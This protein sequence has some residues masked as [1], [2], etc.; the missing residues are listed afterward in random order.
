MDAVLGTAGHIDHGKTSLI[1][2]LTGINCDRLAEEKRRGITIELGFAWLDLPD[3]RRLGIVDVPGHERFVKNMVAGAAGIDCVLLVIAADEGVMPQTREHLEI[4]QLLGIKAGIVALTKIDMVDRDWLEMVR[5]D[6]AA[7]LKGTFLEGAPMLEVSSATGEGIPGL[8]AAVYDLVSSLDQRKGSD[9]LRLP[10]DRVFTLKGHGTVVTGTLVSGECGQGEDVCVMPSGKKARAR[11]LQVH[12]NAVSHAHPGQRCAINLQGLEVSDIGRGDIVSQPDALFPSER[13]L[14]RLSCLAS[15]PLP[16]RQRMETHFHHGSAECAARV[17][18]LD[19]EELQPGESALAELRFEQPMVGIF[20]DR[21]VLRAHSPL[22]T[23]AG[24]VL[25]DPLPEILRRR[26]AV[27]AQKLASLGELANL[28]EMR[29]PEPVRLVGLA[30]AL[31]PLPG[32]N[33]AQLAVLTGLARPEIATALAQLLK[34]GHAV[35][36]NPETGAWVARSQFD[37]SIEC[38]RRRADELHRREPLKTRFAQGAF[39]A[40][41]GDG[42]PPK[43]IQK[44]IDEAARLGLLEQTA[45]GLRLA[46]RTAEL[47]ETQRRI[48]GRMEKAY[49]AENMSP[50]ALKEFCEAE[51]LEMKLVLAVAGHLCDTGKL[52]K[53]QEGFYYHADALAKIR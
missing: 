20:G 21:C 40:G 3:G 10:I 28:A 2:A 32:A 49:G 29:A 44:V 43:Y 19:C 35:C 34:E 48:L 13:W 30:L 24:A 42:L 25:L 41:W 51:R 18:L 53:I 37:A 46:G 27:F 39:C 47:S 23:I 36:W 1:A 45:S 6:V 26:D 22:R 14:V 31:R 50:P 9:I 5:E 52:V 4:C 15:S 16:I 11:S 33:L 38:C 8:R 7:A 12:G 17:V